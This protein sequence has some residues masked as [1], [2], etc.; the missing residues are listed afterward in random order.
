MVRSRVDLGYILQVEQTGLLTFGLPVREG[1][2]REIISSFYTWS[3]G[4]MMIN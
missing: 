3:T 1:G 2:K 4:W